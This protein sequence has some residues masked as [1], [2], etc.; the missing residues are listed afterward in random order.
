MDR[1][2]VRAF[3]SYFAQMVSS[4]FKDIKGKVGGFEPVFLTASFEMQREV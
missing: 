2:S 4:E 1:I 3:L